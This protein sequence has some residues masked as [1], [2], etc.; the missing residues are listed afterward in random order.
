MSLKD[1]ID[2]EIQAMTDNGVPLSKAKGLIYKSLE[3]MQETLS[4]PKYNIDILEITNIYNQK[5][6]NPDL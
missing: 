2:I 4:D 5:F 6:K 1:V 3:S